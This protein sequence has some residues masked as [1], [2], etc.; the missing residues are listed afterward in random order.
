MPIH[1]RPLYSVDR[2]GL[3]ESNYFYILAERPTLT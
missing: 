2:S 1:A 3:C